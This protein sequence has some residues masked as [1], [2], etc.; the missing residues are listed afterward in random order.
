MTK[1]YLCTCGLK[2]AT[3][4][5]FAEQESSSDSWHEYTRG[6]FLRE[7]PDVSHFRILEHL[8]YC[9]VS[10]ESRKKLELTTELGIFVGY[11][12]TPHNY[13]VYF[14]SLKMTVV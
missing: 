10:K 4:G 3:H 2:H 7:K 12:E 8:V 5:L 13:R 9:H 14:P 11:T 6:G 1:A